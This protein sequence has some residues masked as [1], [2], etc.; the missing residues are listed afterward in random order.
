[1]MDWM[2]RTF[3]LIN[4]LSAGAAIFAASLIAAILV[5]T[6]LGRG[7]VIFM[8]FA[9]ATCCLPVLNTVAS[10]IV[11]THERGR[12]MGVTA[13][14]ASVGR[15][16]GP[17]VTGL[18]LAVSDYP[19]SWFVIALPVFLVLLWS[20]TGAARYAGHGGLQPSSP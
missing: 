9:G 1:M 8:A 19:L 3:G 14:A 10:S 2:T 12:M 13:L 6:E 4:V 16:I 20:R 11:D 17:L 18:V 15:V 7:V 5:E